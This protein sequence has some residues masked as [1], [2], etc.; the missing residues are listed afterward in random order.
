MLAYK[1]NGVTYE[2]LNT[3]KRTIVDAN[4]IACKIIHEFFKLSTESIASIFDKHHATVIHYVKLW[5][6]TLTFDKECHQLYSLICDHTIR[7]LY[8]DKLEL[9]DIELDKLNILQLRRLVQ[10]LRLEN[11]TLKNKLHNIQIM[12]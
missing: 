7:E 10:E 4:I 2:M 8:G 12:F 6:N 3:R 1:H 9:N 11:N 5:N